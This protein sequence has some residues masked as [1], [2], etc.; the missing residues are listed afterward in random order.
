MISGT[1]AIYAT[2]YFM[3]QKYA[4]MNALLNIAKTVFRNGWEEIIL[5]LYADKKTY[6]SEDSYLWSETFFITLLS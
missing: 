3:I 2:V 1:H 5:A 6:S 4:A